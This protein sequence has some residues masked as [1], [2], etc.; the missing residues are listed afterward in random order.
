MRSI[1]LVMLS[2]WIIPTPAAA[3]VYRPADCS[4]TTVNDTLATAA[5]SGDTIVCPAGSWSWSNVDITKNITLQGDGIGSTIISITAAAGLDSPTSYTG[6]FRV[7]GFTFVSTANFGTDSGYGMFRIRGNNGFRVDHNELQ[8]FSNV[9]TYNGG[10]GIVTSGAVSGLIDHNRFVPRPGNTGCMHA[11]TYEIGAN[12]PDWQLPSQIGSPDHTVFIEDNYFE[13]NKTGGLCNPHNP[14]AA[15]GQQG[16]FWVFRHNEVHNMNVDAHGFEPTI[17]TREYEVSNNT[18]VADT[19]INTYR[20]MFWRGG[21]GV[22]Y[23]NT[24]VEEGSGSF[25]AA[26]GLTEYRVTTSSRGNPARPE[27]YGGVPA[28]SCCTTNEGYP[29]TDQIGRGQQTGSSPDQSQASDPL[30]IWDNDF[31]AAGMAV[32]VQSAGGSGCGGNIDDY[33][34]AG[35]DY[36]Y[37]G[38]AKPGFVPYVYPHPLQGV[39]GPDAGVGPGPDAGMGGPDGGRTDAGE[40][41]DGGRLDAGE[42]VD[43]GRIDGGARV[44][45]GRIDGGGAT[46]P[47]P[48]DGCGCTVPGGR[49]P[50]A[51]GWVLGAAIAILRRRRRRA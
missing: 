27:L 50:A 37:E 8:I 30:Y 4:Q 1:A 14:H 48:A 43:G 15:Y 16:G 33:I 20:A 23:S 12:L 19:G 35:R 42:R 40:G 7:T 21:T 18:W 2:I 29:C 3:T 47:P 26:I 36:I 39:A 11:S 45:G 49:Q 28:S 13:E 51:W 10:N 9:V 17:S 41:V 31:S 38:G 34:Q 24:L 5:S 46:P 44:D 25:T 22:V 6:A 32:I